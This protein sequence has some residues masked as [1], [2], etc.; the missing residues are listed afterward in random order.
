[1]VSW[2]E[3]LDEKA[4]EQAAAL[5]RHPAVWGHVALMPDC[6]VGFG[7]PIGGVILCPNDVIPNAVGVD[8][9][10]GVRAVRTSVPAERATPDFV[11]AVLDDL[12]RSVPVGEGRAHR[13]PQAWEGFEQVAAP[14]A[15]CDAEAWD[16]ARRNLGTLG[17]GNHFL[18]LQAGDDGRLWCMIHSGSRNVGFR[19]ARHYH[20]RAR[21]I[22]R[23]R[24]TRLPNEE[25]AS[26][27]LDSPEAT[28]YLR[29]MGFALRYAQ[30]N[31]RRM[32]ERFREAIERHAPGAEFEP[33]ID[34]HHNYAAEEEH[35]GQRGWVHRKGATAAREG[36]IGI[37]PGSMG[38]PSYIVRGRGQPESFMSCAHGA[39]RA[40]G[41][42]EACR[43][44]TRAEC[45]AAMAGIVFDGW[46]RRS[47]GCRGNGGEYDLEEAPPAYKPIDAVM[48]A[49][50][51]LVDPLLRL[52]PLGVVKG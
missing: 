41:R 31:R 48:A 12:R 45:D 18:E 38:A 23:Q 15:G 25:L 49:Q 10:C 35:F 51:D 30:E 5:A 27:P 6:H 24:G 37:V 46:R 7:M 9:G 34:V 29:D 1:M 39:G 33:D 32:S 21:A 28:A 19:V 20:A 4:A 16:L 2:C 47:S 26:L 13:R 43:R 11:R 50:R 8:I 17:G 22:C 44:L 36:Q 42:A 40:M 52:R 3:V 14:P